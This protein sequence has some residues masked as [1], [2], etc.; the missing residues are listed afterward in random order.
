MTFQLDLS[1]WRT[2]LSNAVRVLLQF[3]QAVDVLHKP[4]FGAERLLDT[5][6]SSA[7]AK[8]SD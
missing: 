6:P 4:R 7:T 2:D 1:Q 3:E 5:L 8:D